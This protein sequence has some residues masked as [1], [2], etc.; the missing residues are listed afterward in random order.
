MKIEEFNDKE[1]LNYYITNNDIKV[2]DIIPLKVLKVHEYTIRNNPT[3]EYGCANYEQIIYVLK[4]ER[5][6]KE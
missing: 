6:D 2:I 5:S 4:Y 1:S 3:F